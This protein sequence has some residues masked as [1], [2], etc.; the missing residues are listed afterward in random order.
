MRNGLDALQSDQFIGQQF[1]CP[2]APSGGWVT[3]RQGN[4]LLLKRSSDFDL[5]GARDLGMQI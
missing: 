1:E 2:S 5:L 4:Q 3:A